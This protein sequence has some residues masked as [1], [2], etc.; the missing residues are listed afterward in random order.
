MVA[1]IPT[2]TRPAGG[3]VRAWLHQS[4]L[5]MR[6]ESFT[7]F[8]ITIYHINNSCY[9]YVLERKERSAPAAAQLGLAGLDRTDGLARMIACMHA[10]RRTGRERFDLGS[11]LVSVHARPVSGT[12]RGAPILLFELK[13]LDLIR[14][15]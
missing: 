9:L 6:K 2:R 8:F 13:T 1:M 4:S 14:L 3:S 10:C 7:P 11:S 15:A 12:W 5:R